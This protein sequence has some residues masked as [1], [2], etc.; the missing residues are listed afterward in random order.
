MKNCT[1]CKYAKW[2]RTKTGR[3]HP[4]GD[5]E[6]VYP[7]K[8]PSLPAAMFWI[9]TPR[10]MGGFINRREDLKSNCLY[11]GSEA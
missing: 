9:N 5:G 1:G 2:E 10:P 3:L 11:Y 6:C 7:Y 8:V 4:S